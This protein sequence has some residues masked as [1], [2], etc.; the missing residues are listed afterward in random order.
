MEQHTSLIASLLAEIFIPSLSLKLDNLSN[1]ALLF[2]QK[3]Q[4]EHIGVQFET[5]VST[6][7]NGS[8]Y[9]PMNLLL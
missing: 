2:R 1:S 3:F 5:C 4:L 7:D 9:V 8:D 6:L